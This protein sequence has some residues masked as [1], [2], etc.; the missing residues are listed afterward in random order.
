MAKLSQLTV[1]LV[2]ALA[3]STAPAAL[4]TFT[5]RSAFDTALAGLGGIN[6][7][8]IDFESFTGENNPVVGD[9][10]AAGS[11]IQGVTF[12]PALEPGFSL[13]VRGEG[14]TSG[15]NTLGATNDGGVSVGRFALGEGIAFAFDQ[16]TRAFGV[17][18]VVSN[19]FD[20]FTDD[21][22]LSFGG[23]T[24]TNPTGQ[25]GR[26]I[27]GVEA[28]FLGIV[29]DSAGH[30]SASIQFGASAGPPFNTPLFEIDDLN[31]TTPAAPPAT[32][33][34]SLTAPG[35]TAFGNLLVGSSSPSLSYRV[36]NSGDPGSTLTGTVGE[37]LDPSNEFNTSPDQ[38]YNLGQGG[39]LLG[40]IS[41]T[42]GS[43]GL[44][45]ATVATFGSNV[46]PEQSL[47]FTATGVA[48]QQQVSGTSVDFGNV[49]IGTSAAGG[50]SITN[51]GDGGL[52]G[53]NLQ[54]SVGTASGGEFTGGGQAIDLVDGAAQN[55]ALGFA[56]TVAGA[57]GGSV[58]IAFT[59]GSADGT[60]GSD[61]ETV[62]LSGSGV[63]PQ[64]SASATP[65]STLDFGPVAVGDTA[66]IG[67]TIENLADYGDLGDPLTGLTLEDLMLTGTGTDKL[68]V[69]GFTIGQVLS[70]TEQLSL[71]LEFSP[72]TA[73]DLLDVQLT[74]LTD[75]GAPFGG[76]GDDFSFRLTGTGIAAAPMPATSLLMALGL[77]PLLLRRRQHGRPNRDQA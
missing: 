52:V 41:V 40:N 50:T 2:L 37:T 38:P 3:T 76:D 1:G 42:P 9:V 20:F 27:N 61:N 70:E 24:L 16:Q 73:S 67:L 49:R 26:A 31:F 23:T 48:P 21:V 34:L 8:I 10:I 43:R 75:Q 36:E 68:D 18:I 39:S 59:N 47:G 63:G 14:G 45:Q 58:G 12:T 66:I 22:N 54:G 29:D 56:P 32:P 60:N 55:V 28:L 19:N 64:F 57:Q 5:D 11:N 71:S 74:L 44:R 13:A 6:A 69:L 7:E 51:V 35:G 65:G 15:L 4:F 72:V 30:T 25:V 46:A 53:V 17:E 33:A 77:V 62:S